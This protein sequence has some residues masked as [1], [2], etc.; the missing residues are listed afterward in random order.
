M[1]S[2]WNS[3]RTIHI[4]FSVLFSFIL[5]FQ[6]MSAVPIRHV[7]RPEQRDALLKFKNE[8]EIRKSSSDLDCYYDK[9]RAPYWK[10]ESW[11]NNSDCCYWDGIRCD[12]KSGEV[13]ELYLSCSCLH[14]RFHSNTFQNFPFLSS[15]DLS[16]NDLYGQIPS[17]IGKL[18]HLTS[19]DLTSNHFSGQ[20]LSS[21]GTLSN[22]TSLALSDNQF[23]GQ[24]SS[25]IENLS[26]LTSLTLSGNRFPGQ[27]SSSI[28]NLSHL[29]SLDLSYNQFWGQIPSSITKL[30]RLE[31]LH[32]NGNSFNGEI[33]S[34]F[35]SLK[36]LT[37][38][39]LDTNHLSGN[40][41][42]ALLNLTTMSLL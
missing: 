16:R 36:Q 15:L 24:I 21:I 4:T 25:S 19:L 17:S 28:G 1:V 34:S 26:I 8:F 23:S 13:I 29:T 3:M 27:I 22:L 41:P 20:I 40:F 42:I 14:G 7:C 32:L 9:G 18:S 30:S 2:S 33:P 12:A 35:G 10:T 37:Y 39:I 38:L 11:G 5:Y 6:N 31:T